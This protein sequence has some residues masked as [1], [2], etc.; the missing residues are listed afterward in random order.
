MDLSSLYSDLSEDACDEIEALPRSERLVQIATLM[1]R[2]TRELV[3]QVADMAGLPVLND[4]ELIDNPTAT[5]PLRLIHEYQC[6]PV[7]K[8]AWLGAAW[9]KASRV[10]PV[11]SVSRL[12]PMSALGGWAPLPSNL[13]H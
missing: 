5:L 7:R 10:V 13:P 3:A 1:N 4:I 12:S 6:V 2:S 8:S 11:W 9:S